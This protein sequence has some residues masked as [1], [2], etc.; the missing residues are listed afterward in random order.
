MKNLVKRLPYAH[1]VLTFSVLNLLLIIL[2]FI[3][4]NNLPPVLPIYFGLPS[5]NEQLG[6]SEA[7]A[8]LPLAGLIVTF[9]NTAILAF[10][11]DKFLQQVLIGIIAITTTLST[12]AYFRIIFLVGNF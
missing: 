12:F 9:I 7:L 5:G 2:V 1:A 3:I 6:P 8:F 10:T 4:K 11:Q